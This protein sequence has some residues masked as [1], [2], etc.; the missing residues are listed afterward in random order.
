MTPQ[1]KALASAL[2][3][4][5]R[6][7]DPLAALGMPGLTQAVAETGAAQA[8]WALRTW[9]QQVSR[10]LERD[11]PENEEACGV[12]ALAQEL[13]T[14]AATNSHAPAW[15]AKRAARFIQ[16]DLLAYWLEGFLR[17]APRT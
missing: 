9:A 16:P 1:L 13:A 8:E 2:A 4:L 3:Q 17:I 15:L 5:M 6:P 10:S 11:W 12:R 14:G 7:G